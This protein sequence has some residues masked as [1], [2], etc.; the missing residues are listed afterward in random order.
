MEY[1]GHF[2]LRHRAMERHNCAPA[3][4]VWRKIMDLNYLY[5]RYTISLHMAENAACCSSRIVHQKLAEGYAARIAD[6]KLHGTGLAA[7]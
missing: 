1:I 3:F 5:Q 6:A 2:H 7:A 4:S